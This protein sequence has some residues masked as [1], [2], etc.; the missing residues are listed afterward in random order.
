MSVLEDLSNGY[1]YQFPR[2]STSISRPHSGSASK[3]MCK[4]DIDNRNQIQRP[5]SS[6]STKRIIKHHVCIPTGSPPPLNQPSVTPELDHSSPKP[7]KSRLYRSISV[8]L[9]SP[10]LSVPV[11]KYK[12]ENSLKN[13]P[14]QTHEQR[15][16]THE[17]KRRK[18]QAQL[19]ADKYAENDTW[20][21]L[22]RSL[23]EL[24]R[25]AT[26]QEILIDPTTSLSNSDEQSL[27]TL[28]QVINEENKKGM[29]FNSE[30]NNLIVQQ[31]KNNET[32]FSHVSC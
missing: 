23:T 30:S 25:L 27:T 19:L 31:M 9:K 8:R 12:E 5:D 18:Q 7:I 6:S 16:L 4:L 17:R 14:K 3:N 29:M 24:K 22:K 11:S 2:W 21:Q 20:F 13:F 10:A 26:T 15:K 1:N 28:K 32:R